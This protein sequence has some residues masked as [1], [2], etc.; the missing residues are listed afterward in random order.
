[1]TS[2]TDV[3]LTIGFDAD[4]TSDQLASD[5]GSTDGGRPIHNTGL[6]KGE[7]QFLEGET[8]HLRVI[9][10]GRPGSFRSFQIV[11]CCLITRPMV[12]SAGYG[13]P[14]RYAPP[15]PFTQAVGASYQV[16]LDFSSELTQEEPVRIVTQQWK[17]TLDVGNTPGRWDLS[18]VLTVRIFRGP[19]QPD[20]VRVFS[21]DPETEVGSGR[22]KDVPL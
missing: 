7:I 4:Q 20:D 9:G 16:P 21:F 19:N 18:L 13:M 2:T 6:F 17:R 12:V 3:V 1:M 10:S 22:G 11:D 5:F 14:T 15:S 8:L